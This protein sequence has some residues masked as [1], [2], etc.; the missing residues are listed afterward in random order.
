MTYFNTFCAYFMNVISFSGR[1]AADV[2][3][4]TTQ[5]GGC[6]IA[7]CI[8][9]NQYDYATKGNK[10]HSVDFIAFGKQFNKL[11]PIFKKGAPITVMGSLQDNNYI[12]KEGVKH[13][14]KQISVFPGC[15][16]LPS[17]EWSAAHAGD[18]SMQPSV[19]NFTNDD[20][21]VNAPYPAG[22]GTDIASADIYDEDLPF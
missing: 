15:V 1:L 3:F 22:A 19:E 17:R 6:Y 11:H 16:E 8:I 2:R 14:R 12:D 18:T 20:M 5:N 13:Y 9:E 7:G 10:P 21:N 4:G